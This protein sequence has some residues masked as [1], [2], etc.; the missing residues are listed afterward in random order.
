MFGSTGFLLALLA[1]APLVRGSPKYFQQRNTIV[2]YAP[3][4]GP[5]DTAWTEKVG[6]N[7]WPQYPRPQLQ[8]SKWQ[9][10]NGLWEYTNGTSRGDADVDIAPNITGTHSVLVPYC[11]ESALSG[12]ST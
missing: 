9:T 2:A 4:Q 10:L 1:W 12:F 8:R 7:P 5:L 3:K 11:L 6:T